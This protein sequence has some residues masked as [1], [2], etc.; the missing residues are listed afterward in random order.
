MCSCYLKSRSESPSGVGFDDFA[1]FVHIF[2]SLVL[3]EIRLSFKFISTFIRMKK[4]IINP[5]LKSFSDQRCRKGNFS[6]WKISVSSSPWPTCKREKCIVYLFFS[7]TLS[8][9]LSLS[10]S[11]LKRLFA[12][13][14]QNIH[15]LKNVTVN[16]T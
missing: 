8:F 15:K 1:K 3:T 2:S 7:W 10:T 5:P 4:K 11:H 16:R 12:I 6:M 13:P 14:L 9:C